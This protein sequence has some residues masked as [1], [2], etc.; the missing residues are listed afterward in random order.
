MPY[1]EGRVCPVISEGGMSQGNCKLRT[2]EEEELCSGK[3]KNWVK[4]KAAGIQRNRKSLTC[5][6]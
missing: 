1:C 4:V 5:I 2:E 6:F 3:K